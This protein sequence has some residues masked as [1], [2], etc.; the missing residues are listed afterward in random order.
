MSPYPDVLTTKNA[1]AITGY[2][3]NSV[4]KWCTKGLLES[5]YVSNQYL[6]PKTYLLDFMVGPHFRGVKEEPN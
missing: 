5:L 2:N 3:R 4:S 6:I 1:A